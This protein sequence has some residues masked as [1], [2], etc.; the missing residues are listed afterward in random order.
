MRQAPE[1]GSIEDQPRVHHSQ[2]VP[3]VVGPRLRVLF[4]GVNPGIRSGETHH[5][6][7]HPS[8]RLWTALYASGFT[9]QLL[10]PGGERALLDYDLGLTNL[11]DRPTRAADELTV[12]ELRK[13]GAQLRLKACRY[14]PEWVAILGVVAYRIAFEEPD[15]TVGAQRRT[16]CSSRLWVL[17][18]P[19]GRNAHFPLPKLIE[20]FRRL[21]RRV[22]PSSE[23]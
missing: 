6:F 8:S 10:R 2:I 13:G 1:A 17:P 21:R 20:E 11:V 9:S 16:L 7:A 12:A 14:R 5:H 15:A 22:R 4:V 19:T 18:G 3:D 23:H